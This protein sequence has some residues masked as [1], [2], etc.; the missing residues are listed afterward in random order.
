MS[1]AKITPITMPKW[2]LSMV[3]G[4]VIEW[5]VDENAAIA[6]G[7]EIIDIET[8]KIANTFEA[9][10]GGVLKRI[11]AAADETLPI[12]ALLGVLAAADT[13]DAEVDAFIAEFQANYVP[14][15]I[16]EEEDAGP[17]YARV[18]VDGYDIRYLRLGD[19]ADNVILIHGFGGDLDGWLLTQEPLAATASVYALD[20]PGHGQST[21]AV[22]DG[23][24]AALAD[25]IAKFMAALGIDRAHL[26]GHSLG[27]AVAL[28]TAI[29]HGDKVSALS[30]IASAGL[31]KEI[32]G[33]YLSGFVAAES[34]RD[35]KPL[36]QQL[37]A[38]PDLINRTLVDDILKFKRTD[39]VTEAL[40]TVAQGFVDGDTQKISLRDALGGLSIPVRV[41]WGSADKIIPAAHADGLPA[42][43]DVHILDGSGHLVQLEAASEVNKLLQS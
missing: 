14:P 42:N 26:V 13:P 40:T 29:A 34:R 25:V 41:I 22:R 27:G 9:L 17:S 8:E 7:D 21:K 31:G 12:G 15:E 39:G 28:Q 32:N 20:L 24:V 19:G 6:V 43:V 4:K 5:L 30:L 3:E 11:V 36:L 37:V 35:I 23:S 38:N 18:D 16:D 1:D 10:D 2:G 33:G